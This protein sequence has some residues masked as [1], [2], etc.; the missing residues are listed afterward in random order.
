MTSRE[1]KNL[2]AEIIH[3][4]TIIWQDESI[5]KDVRAINRI[6]ADALSRVLHRINQSERFEQ[7]P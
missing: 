1:I 5:N 3:D 7:L 2:I 6:E 4:H